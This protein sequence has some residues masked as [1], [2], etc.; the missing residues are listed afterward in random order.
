MNVPELIERKREG[1]VTSAEE[2]EFLLKGFLDETIPA[3]QMSAWLMAVLHRG[4]TAQETADLTRLMMSSGE[5]L[6]LVD[7]PGV[8]VD[9]HS[10]G[11]VG[12]KISI[13]LAPAVASAG[14][15]IPMISGR[16]LG[17]TGGTLD[18]LESIPGLS[19]SLDTE[20]FRRVIREVG[21]SIIG[22]NDSLAPADR[23]L[24]E[25]RDVTGTVPSIPLIT[26]SILS[27]K[28]AAGVDALVL[29]VKSGT[30]AFM[31]EPEE[32]A[33]LARVLVEVSGK[34]GKKATALVT[35]MDQP[36]GRAVG[37][38]LEIV[39]SIEV[40]RGEGP[41]D[42]VELTLVLGAEMT[43][44]GGVASDREAGRALVKEKIQSGEALAAFRRWVELQGGDPATVDDPSRLPSA[45]VVREIPSERTG[46]LAG[47]DTR[48]IG[49]AANALGAGR[50]RLGDPVDPSVGFVLRA[51]LGDRV[52]SGRSLADVHANT[53]EDAARAAGRFRAAVQIAEEAVAAPALMV[54]PARS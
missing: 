33:E 48:E 10:T 2:L 28:F 41:P 11:G 7:L 39:E 32:A 47:F 51:K 34:L 4:M 15:T 52:E 49:L 20:T 14:V 37:N 13:P 31:R 42:V 9:K 16:G 25:L 35:S 24:Y 8:K 3:Y 36:L 1:E 44:L 6:S 54:E 27:K 45:P 38:A 50:A 26:G 29:D 19:T 43:V 40:L 53:D 5:V 17:H 21:Y 46:F 22:A 12:D 30:G 18:K 23:K